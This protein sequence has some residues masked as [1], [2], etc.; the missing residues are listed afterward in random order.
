VRHDLDLAVALLADLDG[1]AEVIGAPIN[2]DAVV[3]ELFERGHVEDLVR[4]RLR[5]VDDELRDGCVSS[6]RLP[7]AHFPITSRRS[8]AEGGKYLLGD[9]AALLAGGLA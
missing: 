2:L 6:C 1:F 5:G 8:S 3:Q 9:L 7:K 4:R